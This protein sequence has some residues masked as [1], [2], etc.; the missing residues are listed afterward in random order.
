MFYSTLLATPPAPLPARNRHPRTL[1]HALGGGGNFGE[2]SLEME[3]AEGGRM[4]EAR[5]KAL[6]EIEEMRKVLVG[7]EKELQGRGPAW[8]ASLVRY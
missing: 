7:H 4:D 2:F 8:M 5:K 1:V 6:G 3:S